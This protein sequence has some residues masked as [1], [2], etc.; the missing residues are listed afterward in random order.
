VRVPSR[1][2][3]TSADT[4]PACHALPVAIE[5]VAHRGAN[6]DEP[7]HSLAAYLRAIDDGADAVECDVRLTA[8]GALV[9]VH[10]RRIDRT[11]TG[12]GSVSAKRLADLE[13]HDYSGTAHIWHDFEAP[14][15]D[16][17]R[18]RVLTLNVLLTA[19]ME[20]SSTIKFAIETKHPT[21]FGAYVEESLAETLERF[22]LARP[23]R[24]GSSRVRVMSFSQTA[25]RRMG[26]LTPGIPTVFLM[27][28]VPLR[29]RDGT[30]PLGV[31]IAGPS[32]EIIRAH[33]HYV[34]R[35]HDRGGLV[36]VWT[37]DEPAD[38][39]LCA[40]LGVDAII[41]NRPAMVR[42]RLNRLGA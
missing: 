35:V 41:S 30:L 12:K 16:E 32:I 14:K 36:H 37:V 27:S 7:E 13:R 9:L 15:P 1:S 6:E 10:D 18:S 33:P 40:A 42:D 25:V 26:A 24:D 39:D 28:R 2:K 22:G 17:T 29:M 31:P 5:V 38:V 11:S 8:D 3:S 4:P 34:E 19:L 21:R 23:P 20:R